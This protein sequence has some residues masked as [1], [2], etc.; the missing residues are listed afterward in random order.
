MLPKAMATKGGGPHRVAL[1]GDEP[2]IL[3]ASIADASEDVW[4]DFRNGAPALI[5]FERAAAPG[6]GTLL[7][8]ATAVQARPTIGVDESS[9]TPENPRLACL[10]R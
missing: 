4:F 10:P 6:C 1:V 5:E 2:Q 3:S 7:W 9:L 8:F